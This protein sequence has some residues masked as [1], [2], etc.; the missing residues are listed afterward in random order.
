MSVSQIL[1]LSIAE[2]IGDFGFKFFAD[3]GGII[4]FVVGIIGYI[5][6]IIYLIIS[7]QHSSI[8]MVNGAWDGMS[9][10]LE[11][12]AGFIFLGERFNDPL[13]YG[14]LIVIAFGLYLLRIPIEKKE[15]FVWPKFW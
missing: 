14:G 11:S 15:R 8:M 6:V 9:G 3:G 10:L 7:L 12:A 5:G 2:I 13:Q 4:P 1:L